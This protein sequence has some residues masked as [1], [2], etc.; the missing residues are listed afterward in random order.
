VPFYVYNV[1]EQLKAKG[2]T[3]VIAHPERNTQIQYDKRAMKRLAR[4]GALSQVTGASLSGA[5]GDAARR[6]GIELLKSGLAHVIASDGH[7]QRYPPVLS[8]AA[9]EVKGLIG[10][11]KAEKL[12][13][14]NPEKII[15]GEAI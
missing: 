6:S 3:P 11:G 9:L 14:V 10:K 15:R 13:V 1:I 12:F 8:E 4:S 7:N 2:I 5:Y